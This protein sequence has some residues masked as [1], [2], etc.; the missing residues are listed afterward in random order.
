LH[1][2]VYYNKKD[3]VNPQPSLG[4]IWQNAINRKNIANFL[5][6]CHTGMRQVREITADGTK[7]NHWYK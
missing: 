6:S 3:L 1:F 4:W 7:E 5:Y 2:I